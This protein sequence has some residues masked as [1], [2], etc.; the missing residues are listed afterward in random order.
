VIFVQA[1]AFCDVCNKGTSTT[2]SFR[3]RQPPALSRRAFDVVE[4]A[5]PAYCLAGEKQ[6]AVVC[7]LAC[8]AQWNLAEQMATGLKPPNRAASMVVPE[9]T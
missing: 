2:I 5:D 6:E 9:R 3:P 1:T 8:A 4:I 7:S